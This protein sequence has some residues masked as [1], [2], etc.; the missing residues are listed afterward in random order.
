[1]SFNIIIKRNTFLEENHQFFIF[2]SL[3]VIYFEVFLLY[4]FYSVETRS[5][6]QTTVES[7]RLNYQICTSVVDLCLH[8]F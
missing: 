6:R 7:E 8:L 1:M 2:L 3:L 4:H 5:G